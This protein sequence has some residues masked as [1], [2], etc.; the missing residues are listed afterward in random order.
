MLMSFFK[1][2]VHV[3]LAQRQCYKQNIMVLVS[4]IDTNFMYDYEA[5]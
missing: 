2:P 3:C 5:Q 4:Q 1:K